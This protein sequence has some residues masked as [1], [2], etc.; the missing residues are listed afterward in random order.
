MKHA[1]TSSFKVNKIITVYLLGSKMKQNH[2]TKLS[3]LNLLFFLCKTSYFGLFLV[4][5]LVFL[6][7]AI[8][9]KANDMRIKLTSKTFHV[10][11]F[12]QAQNSV[13]TV[14]LLLIAIPEP[15]S[16]AKITAC[17]F[18]KKKN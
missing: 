15:F 2:Y 13:G 17:L 1:I 18:K 4:F 7:K 5:Q 3:Q 14:G 16:Y 6:I 10:N 8:S 12:S 9:L 11:N